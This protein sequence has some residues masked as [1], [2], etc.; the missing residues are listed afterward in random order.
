[1]MLTPQNIIKVVLDTF[2]RESSMRIFLCH[3]N[4]HALQAL[5]LQQNDNDI[6]FYTK[7]V[8]LTFIK[9]NFKG[10]LYPIDDQY[11]FT[12]KELYPLRTLLKAKNKN[13]HYF[14]GNKHNFWSTFL[15]N[16]I[17]SNSINILDDGLSSYGISDELYW[18]KNIFKKYIKRMV[19]KLMNI[20]GLT[21][22]H[23]SNNA[24]IERNCEVYYFFKELS[25]VS[26][27][28]LKHQ[29]KFHDF[30]E[31]C[32]QYTPVTYPDCLYV[33]SFEQSK[34]LL[35][36]QQTN[37][38]LHPRVTGKP[39]KIPNEIVLFHSKKVSL[40]ASSLILYLVFSGYEGEYDFSGDVYAEK[41]FK[42]FS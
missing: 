5:S 22:F 28:A 20:G 7:A 12:L 27:K 11:D 17:P 13:L 37:Y 6:C 33:A 19:N 23:E 35:G 2:D 10:A 25:P 31:Y 41:I 15:L 36:Q 21:Y 9:D 34:H 8:S 16:Q 32:N 4:L 26:S 38:L 39:P 40:S 29:L 14:L 24:Q 42:F 30:Q 1:M 3:S 18:E